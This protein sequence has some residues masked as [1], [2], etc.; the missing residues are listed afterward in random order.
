M[1]EAPFLPLYCGDYL[2]DTKDLDIAQ[3]GAYLMILMVTWR[4]RGQALPDDDK[5]LARICGLRVDLWRKKFRPILARFFDL[6]SGSWRQKRLD[7]EWLWV[8][9]RREVSR[10]NGAKGGRPIVLKTKETENPAGSLRVYNSTSTSTQINHQSSK[11]K[12]AQNALVDEQFER[13]WIGYPEKVGKKV[14]RQKFGI[15]IKKQSLGDLTA[16]VERYKANKP[17]DRA[18]LNPATWL[19]QERWLDVPAVN[20]SA[21]DPPGW[22]PEFSFNVGPTEPAPPLDGSKIPVGRPH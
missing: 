10:L 21:V 20:G 17:A 7:K 8:Q 15:A 3:H 14:A 6:S 12:R 18:W 11:E 19:H 5:V 1:S 13:W 22:R 4:N 2:A 9:K 16:A